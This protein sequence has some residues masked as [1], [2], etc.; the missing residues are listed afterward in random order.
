MLKNAA[1]CLV[2]LAPAA[3]AVAWL[4]HYAWMTRV[5]GVDV[6]V[7]TVSVRLGDLYL[8]MNTSKVWWFFAFVAVSVLQ[9][10]V[11]RRLFSN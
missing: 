7:S 9:V 2:G 1:A 6:A 8:V 11:A 3:L 4:A 5:R 10:A